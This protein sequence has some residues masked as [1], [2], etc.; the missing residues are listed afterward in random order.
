[1]KKRDLDLLIVFGTNFHVGNCRYLVGSKPCQGW[2]YSSYAQGYGTEIVTVPMSGDPALWVF[3]PMV[4]WVRDEVA[5]IGLYD[6]P[7]IEVK[8]LNAFFNDVHRLARHPKRVA[9]EGRNITPWPIYEKIRKQMGK[10][11]PETDIVEVQRRIK[12]QKEI[13]LLEVASRINDQICNELVD[14][15]IRCGVTEKEVVR[16]ICELAYSMGVE[17]CDANFMISDDLGWAHSRDRTIDDGQLL[18]LHV[19]L[20]YEGYFSDNDRVFGFG[21]VSKED[22]ELARACRLALEAGLRTIKPGIKGCEAMEAAWAA[23]KHADHSKWSLDV[24]HSIGL[25]GEE[26]YSWKDWILEK[27]MVL[28]FSPG[29]CYRGRTWATEDVIHVTANGARLLTK[30]PVDHVIRRIHV[31]N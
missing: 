3:E 25:E 16:K 23:H 7:W 15:V 18:S 26:L 31:S 29:A 14:G 19:I 30:F 13:K 9:Y 2:D 27:N 1:M 21:H 11:L 20:S 4:P 5:S 6:E 8:T 22:E 17:T 10:D 24:G 12:E 28:C